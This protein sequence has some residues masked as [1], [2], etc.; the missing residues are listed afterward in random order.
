M[1]NKSISQ[2]M[3]K[4]GKSLAGAGK[5]FANAGWSGIPTWGKT[6]LFLGV[7]YLGYRVIKTAISNSRLDANTRD[8]KQ[9]VD[10]WFK[11]YQEDSKANPPKMSVTMQKSL[12]NKIHTAMDGYGTRDYDL[13]QAFKQIKTNA[14]FSGVNAMYGTRTLQ[15][16][17]GVGWMISSFK[18]TMIQCI[19]DDVSSST[20]DE[21]NKGLKA[22]GI[23]YSV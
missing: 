21:I 12:A 2:G 14:D 20:I 22:R 23:K 19:E 11:S 4:T 17:H 5:T 3:K 15:P 1:T 13:K 7:G 8:T 9:E 10:G 6:I 18:G 16:G